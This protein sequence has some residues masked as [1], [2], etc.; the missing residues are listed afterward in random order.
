MALFEAARDARGCG[1]FDDTT[2]KFRLLYAV[3]WKI[4][5]LPVSSFYMFPKL[6]FVQAIVLYFSY[7]TM[8]HLSLTFCSSNSTRSVN[9]CSQ[10]FSMIQI[11]NVTLTYRLLCSPFFGD[12]FSP[13]RQ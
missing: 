4:T 7:T 3:S 11:F 5:Y 13:L 2:I 9:L 12:T 10:V 1:N 6:H 8:P